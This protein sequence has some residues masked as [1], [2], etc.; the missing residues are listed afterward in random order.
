MEWII[1]AFQIWKCN[2]LS[3]E[4]TV[5]KFGWDLVL[6]KINFDLFKHKN[7]GCALTVY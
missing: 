5:N 1:D 7:A 2:G 3:A 4:I 6:A